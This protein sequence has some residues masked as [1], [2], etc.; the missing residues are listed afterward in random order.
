MLC[1][2][3]P[4]RLPKLLPHKERKFRSEWT[5]SLCRLASLRVRNVERQPSKSQEITRW[6]LSRCRLSRSVMFLVGF[7]GWLT[8]NF[9]CPGAQIGSENSGKTW[10]VESP[11]SGVELKEVG[12]E[13]HVPERSL[14]I[15]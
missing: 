8:L 5:E 9:C 12:S 2:R 4:S 10:H 7:S 14:L 15:L 13:A 6:L 11:S 1:L 3:T